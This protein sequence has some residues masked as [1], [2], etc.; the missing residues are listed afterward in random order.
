MGN[1]IEKLIMD[2]KQMG[3]MLDDRESELR[4]LNDPRNLKELKGILYELD[5]NL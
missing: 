1:T 2:K 4:K 5:Q 3:E